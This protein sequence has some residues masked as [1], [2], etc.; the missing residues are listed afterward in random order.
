MEIRLIQHSKDMTNAAIREQVDALRTFS[1]LN[2]DT[3]ISLVHRALENQRF[4]T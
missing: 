3:Q 2:Q 4:F 1:S